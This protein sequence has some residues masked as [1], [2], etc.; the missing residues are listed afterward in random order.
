MTERNA[1]VC[2]IVEDGMKIA[3]VFLSTVRDGLGIAE[4]PKSGGVASV[5]R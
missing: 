2:S 5:G 1:E 3:G 4:V